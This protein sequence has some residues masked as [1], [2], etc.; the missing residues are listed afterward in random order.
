VRR[1]IACGI[2][3]ASLCGCASPS[4]VGK[5]TAENM[6]Y[7]KIHSITMQMNADGT[8][9]GVGETDKPERFAGS[10]KKD[11]SG[12]AVLNIYGQEKP[13]TA[14][15]LGKDRMVVD[16]DAGPPVQFKR[17][18]QAATTQT[19]AAQTSDSLDHTEHVVQ[20]FLY[21]DGHFESERMS[22]S[23][24]EI[25]RFAHEVGDRSVKIFPVGMNGKKVTFAQAADLQDSL[26]KAGVKNV[27]IAMEGE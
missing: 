11:A 20:V 1:T 5:W 26:K 16:A 14:T 18:D 8:L 2:V 6:P 12:K 9:S 4:Y 23:K 21:P 27:T 24:D 22:I 13:G 17:L 25:A 19:A 7:D 10:W 15:L 3:L